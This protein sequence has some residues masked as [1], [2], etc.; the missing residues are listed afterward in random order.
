[1][2]SLILLARSCRKVLTLSAISSPLKL[3]TAQRRKTHPQMFPHEG[4]AAVVLAAA[5]S[6]ALH[7]SLGPLALDC[8]EANRHSHSAHT[9]W[10]QHWVGPDHKGLGVGHP[11]GGPVCF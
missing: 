10:A 4:P 1:M 9:R 6:F 11:L 7:Q 2:E 5:W 8:G 3:Q